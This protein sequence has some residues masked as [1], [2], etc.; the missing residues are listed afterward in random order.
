[1]DLKQKIEEIK[2]NSIDIT[3]DS[4]IS[5]QLPIGES[6]FG[7]QPDL[8]K[9][10]KWYYF[11]GL[12]PFTDEIAERPL[13]FLAQI[14][15]E[16]VKKYDLD[17]RLPSKGMLYFFYEL[18]TMVWGFDPKDRG[19]AKV[20][21]Y[22]GEIEELVRTDFPE[23]MDQ[24][25]RLPEVKMFFDSKYNAP[26]FDEM[27]NDYQNEAW[28]EYYKILDKSG[29]MM[30]GDNSS[31]LLGY[32]DNIQGDM[33][34]QCQLVTNGIYCGESTS[35]ESPDAKELEKSREQWKLLLQLD[36]ITTNHFEL[37]FGDFGRIYYY[38]K[39]ED[40]KNKN[41]ENTWLVLQCS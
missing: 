4:E 1:M 2:L 7:G 33:L 29:Y 5:E 32:A 14:N 34:T 9:G 23:D 19:S 30:T 18:E 25:F 38:I 17:N 13:S 16:E 37:M 8:P 36:T 10:F 31:K 12:S 28:E 21:Y 20:Y 22:D 27:F 15:C 11:K 35:Y 6:K 41:F 26:T 24:E 40:L 39:D 3:I